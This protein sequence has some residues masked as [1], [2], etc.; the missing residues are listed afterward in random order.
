VIRA[1]DGFQVYSDS[2]D[3]T[4]QDVIEVQQDIAERIAE[5]LDVV[6]DDEKREAMFALGTRDIDAYEHFL[7]G[8]QL[9]H[10]WSI[11]GE[12]STIWH[13]NEWLDKAIA[14]DPTFSTS[15]S[16]RS[17]AFIYFL[18]G[19][20]PLPETE[21]LAEGTD[22]DAWA[23][24]QLMGDVS[25]AVVHAQDP[26]IRLLNQITEVIL[27][28]DFGGLP[29]LLDQVDAG[30]MANIPDIL[31]IYRVQI[32]LI[33]LGHQDVALS[34]GEQRIDLNPLSPFS[35]SQA[36]VAALAKGDIQRAMDFLEQGRQIAGSAKFNE[37]NSTLTLFVAGR[38]N[39]AI[40]MA[41]DSSF[42]VQ[43]TRKHYLAMFYAFAGRANEAL[44][45]LEELREAK[46]EYIYTAVALRELGEYEA[47]QRM[48]GAIDKRPGGAHRLLLGIISDFGG[49]IP[50]DLD[51]TPNLAARLAEAGVLLEPFEFQRASGDD[52]IEVAGN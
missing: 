18:L 26:G 34:I 11:H 35:Y 37:G 44:T 6:L 23:L 52:E 33:L 50:F 7:R 48:L 46:Q 25:K 30:S 36:W 39:D 12:A 24:D 14:A 41:E 4:M 16:L 21:P 49:R 20:L 2:I 8:R 3:R 51:W 47:A 29:L 45:L 31:D 10:E 27:S 32:A 5:S 19:V 17:H 43:A 15:Y 40:S 38:I 42:G 22:A 13:A 1:Q 9:F 28:N